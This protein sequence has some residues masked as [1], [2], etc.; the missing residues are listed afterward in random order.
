MVSAA[1]GRLCVETRL[2]RVY[3]KGCEPAAFRRLGIETFNPLSIFEA[4][5]D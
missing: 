5:V 2:V 4:D 1:F 3:D